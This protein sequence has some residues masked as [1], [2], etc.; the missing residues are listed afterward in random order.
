MNCAGFQD[1]L[2]DEDTRQAQ[3]GQRPLPEDLAGHMRTCVPCRRAYD[4]AAKDE[5]T[6]ARQIRETPSDET[7]ARIL[8]RIRDIETPRPTSSSRIF[9]VVSDAL[10]AGAVAVALSSALQ[11]PLS[12]AWQF[13][14]FSLGAAVA[15]CRARIEGIA[16]HLERSLRLLF[17]PY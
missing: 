10:T 14:A 3:R 6:L 11:G 9:P 15:L 2:Y 5:T 12:L 17:A 1:R 16:Q 4:E 8:G 13:S 7:R